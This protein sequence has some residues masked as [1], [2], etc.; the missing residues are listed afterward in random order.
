M[1]DVKL[2]DILKIIHREDILDEDLIY[3]DEFAINEGLI[4]T[5]PLDKTISILQS[6][7]FKVQPIE[8]KNK[9]ELIIPKNNIDRLDKCIT[10]S[11]NLGWFP[12]YRIE[13]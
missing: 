13:N 6:S 5:W 3:A 8:G 2:Q 12:S 4:K 1:S 7:H 10:L 9:Y 11:S